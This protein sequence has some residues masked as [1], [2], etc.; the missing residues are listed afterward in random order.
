MDYQ[1][2]DQGMAVSNDFA[3]SLARKTVATFKLLEVPDWW[4]HVLLTEMGLSHPEGLS[5]I[6]GTF[7]TSGE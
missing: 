7:A 4:L 1:E 2:S 5:V 6:S 3:L